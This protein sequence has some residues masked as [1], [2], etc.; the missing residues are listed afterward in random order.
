[1]EEKRQNGYDQWDLPAFKAVETELTPL[2][3]FLWVPCF[4]WES[5]SNQPLLCQ[6]SEERSTQAEGQTGVPEAIDNEQMACRGRYKGF[7]RWNC[8]NEGR[9]VELFANDDAQ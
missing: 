1:M 5:V 7:V 9:V 8:G 3:P 2:R 4:A 6:D